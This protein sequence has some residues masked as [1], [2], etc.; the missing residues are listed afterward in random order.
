MYLGWERDQNSAK[1]EA[2]ITHQVA[3]KALGSAVS[4]EKCFKAKTVPNPAFCIPTWKTSVRH[5]FSSNL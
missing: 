1:I 4:G 3:N 2:V 5:L